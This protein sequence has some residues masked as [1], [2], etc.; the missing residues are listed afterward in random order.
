MSR[1]LVCASLALLLFPLT[2][3][4][5][6]TGIHDR[7]VEAEGPNGA[8]VSFMVAVE[9]GNDGSDGRPADTVTCTPAS[10]TLLP[11]GS[12]IVSCVGSEGSTGSFVVT[13]VDRT[14]PTLTVPRDFTVVTANPSGEAVTFS[15]TASDLVDGAVAVTCTPASGSTFALGTTPVTCTASD[16]QGNTASAGFNLTVAS[17]PPPPGNPDIVAE[18]TG[19]DGARVAF[20]TGDSDDDDGRPGSGGCSP[21]PGS[22]FPLGDTVVTCPS[23]NFTISVVDTTP[24]ALTLPDTITTQDEV[25]TFTATASD[26]VDG[27]VAVTCTPPSGSTFA[28][29]TTSVSCSATDSHGN[30]AS[31][32]F[33]VVVTTG[34]VPDPTDITAEASGANG[35]IVVFDPGQNGSGRPNTCTP[36]SGS[37]FPLGETEVTC[38]SGATFTVTVVDTTPPVLTLPANQTLEA[39]SSA[40]ATATFSATSFDLVDGSVAVS[41]T[42]SSGSTFALGTTTVNCSATDAHDNTS[43]GSFSVTVV[44]TTPPVLT[45]PADLTLEAT[46]AAG[47]TATFTATASDL[48]DGSVAV[49]CAPPSGSTFALG[50][51]SVSCSATDAH[52]NGSSGSFSVT[53]VDTTPPDITSVTADPATLWPPNKKLVNV[54]VTVDAEDLVDPAPLVRIY[55]ITCDETINSTDAQITGLLTARLRA[56]RLGNGDGRVYTLHIEVLDASGNR[57]TATVTVTVPHDQ[58]SNDTSTQQ[59]PSRRRS[60]RG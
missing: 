8:L 34:P 4:A 28:L 23:G 6:L 1:L 31:G 43:S 33:Q 40:G 45:L 44:D 52:D 57:A 29:G 21:A 39:T 37:T 2:A 56:D 15:A 12:T 10:G 46:S 13:V 41:C 53:V 14:P 58:N 20:N 26:L 25:V 42:P 50:T 5:A 3:V 38:S 36:P 35:A 9:G 22:T 59:A 60:A 49:V 47:A 18:A 11:L 48:V 24:P 55:D 7:I 51:T 19:A 54:T 30:S 27:S 16:S 17:E 32:S